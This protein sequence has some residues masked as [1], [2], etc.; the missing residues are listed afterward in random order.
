MSV[1]ASLKKPVA[2]LGAEQAWFTDWLQCRITDYFK[3]EDNTVFPVAPD[4]TGH[5][6]DEYEQQIIKLKLNDSERLVLMLALIP[7]L[8]PDAL[9]LLFTRNKN[10]DRP[11]SE[12]GGVP[13]KAHGGFIPTLETALF[14]LAGD[15]LSAR[16]EAMSLL[17][18]ASPLLK[19][20][21]IQFTHTESM[22]SETAAVL[23]VSPT[24]LKRV[25]GF[26]TSVVTLGGNFPAQRITTGIST[27]EIVISDEVKDELEIIESWIRAQPQARV[28]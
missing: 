3:Q 15:D 28:L 18:P 14:V 11:F 23:G 13:A 22:E 9:D 17:S 7:W 10:I 19:E 16:L 20:N 8:K 4:L 25:T 12:F 1:G 6:G 21:I 27:E 26:N 5:P 2:F 24:F